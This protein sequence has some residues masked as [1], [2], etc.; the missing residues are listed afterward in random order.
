MLEAYR[1]VEG[2]PD[3]KNRLPA[4]P[5]EAVLLNCIDRFGVKAV[6]GRDVLSHGEIN[7]MLLADR[8]IRAYASR[9]ASGD[10]GKWAAANPNDDALLVH[11]ETMINAD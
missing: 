9:R 2:A 6:M 3:E 7:R 8:I 5:H 1:Y 4:P 10:W 11:V